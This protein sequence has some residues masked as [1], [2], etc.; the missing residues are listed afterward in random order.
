MFVNGDKVYDTVEL[1]NQDRLI[2]GTNSTFLVVIPGGEPR[3][4]KLPNVVDWEFAQ[5]ELNS[6]Y[7]KRKKE[8]EEE[9]Q[10]QIDIECKILLN[11]KIFLCLY[12]YV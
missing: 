1:Q 4:D 3:H 8:E 5:E 9:Q 7:D 6:K 10:K 12:I 2:F 11:R